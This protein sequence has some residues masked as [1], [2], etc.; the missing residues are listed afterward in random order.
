MRILLLFLLAFSLPIASNAQ[1]QGGFIYII[2]KTA[3]GNVYYMSEYLEAKFP[4]D[5]DG[6]D[7]Q[8]KSFDQ[9]FKDYV[10]ENYDL[11]DY[12]LVQNDW[13]VPGR[14]VYPDRAYAKK[15]E[16]IPVMDEGS[17]IIIVEGFKLIATK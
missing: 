17:K 5:H 1:Q 12:Q 8:R 10:L 14:G 3:E 7:A 4:G 13:M 11:V 16:N 15:L 9:K 6:I 2:D